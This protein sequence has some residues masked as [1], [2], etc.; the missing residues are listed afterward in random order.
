MQYTQRVQTLLNAIKY[1]AIVHNSRVC[2]F[3]LG[4]ISSE[5]PCHIMGKFCKQ[6][7][8]DHVQDMCWVLCL[9]VAVTKNDIFK[10]LPAC[11]PTVSKLVVYIAAIIV[12]AKFKY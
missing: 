7:R 4:P 2:L 12:F 8:D 1:S 5:T 11:R 10:K 9:W 3:C 6:T